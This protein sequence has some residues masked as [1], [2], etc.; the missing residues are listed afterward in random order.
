MFE[1][2][3]GENRWENEWKHDDIQINPKLIDQKREKI[4]ATIENNNAEE[5]YPYE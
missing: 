3:N 1:T 5:N 2:K 4:T